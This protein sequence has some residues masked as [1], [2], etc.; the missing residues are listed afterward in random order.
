LT[1]WTRYAK[2]VFKVLGIRNSG[3]ARLELE[4]YA[5]VSALV[6]VIAN[7]ACLL[8]ARRHWGGSPDCVASGRLSNYDNPIL[9]FLCS[10]LETPGAVKNGSPRNA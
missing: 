3:W 7:A 5:M 9:A 8:P 4:T 10:G 1:S 2:A 6:F